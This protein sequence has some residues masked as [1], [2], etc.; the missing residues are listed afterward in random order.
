[1]VIKKII[2]AYLF[3]FFGVNTVSAVTITTSNLPP[4]ITDQPFSLDVSVSGASAGTNYLRI[5][6]YKEGTTN[7]FGETYVNSGWYRGSGG[8]MYF[9]ITIVSKQT[10]SGSIQGRVGNPTLTEFPETGIY[11][12]RIRRYT[13]SGNQASSDKQ[14]PQDINI[15]LV[16]TSPSISPTPSPVSSLSAQTPTPTF[17]TYPTN[18]PQTLNQNTTI[19]PSSQFSAY[20]YLKNRANQATASGQKSQDQEIK[21]ASVA[22]ITSAATKPYE[23]VVRSNTQANLIRITGFL[24]ILLGSGVTTYILLKSR[25]K[26]KAI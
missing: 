11:K 26:S 23:P 5:D 10:W 3:L 25:I 18:S 12:L 8:K 20:A 17:Q 21:T 13:N 15:T 22:A 16:Q 2:L 14:T 6:L 19:K 4:A 1:M 7:Y 9:P 24:L